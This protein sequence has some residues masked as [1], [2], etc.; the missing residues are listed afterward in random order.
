MKSN[1]L[2]LLV[3]VFL[4]ACAAPIFLSSAESYDPSEDYP[5]AAP[6]DPAKLQKLYEKWEARYIKNG[7]DANLVL[8]LKWSKGLSDEFTKAAGYTKV[9]LIEGKIFVE[10]V[11]LPKE[12]EWDF[13]L[14]DDKPGEGRS[15]M[16]EKTDVMRRVGTL[17]RQGKN[18]SLEANLGPEAFGDFEPDLFIVTQAGKDPT[19]SRIL[20]GYMNLY[21]SLYRSAQKGQFGVL[22]GM[23][24][25]PLPSEKKLSVW[26]RIVN[27]ISPT[28]SAQFSEGPVIQPIENIIAQ[29]KLLFTRETFA[30]NGRTC[31]S[32]HPIANNFTIDPPFIAT[33]P[34]SDPLFVAETNPA[35]AQLEKPLLMRQVG[36]ILENVDGLQNPTV[37]FVMRSVPHTLALPT[38][39]DPDPA[40]HGT[41]TNATGWSGD[42]A[43]NGEQFLLGGN[44]PPHT[45]TGDLFD[46]AIGAVRQHFTKTLNRIPSGGGV[47]GDFR[48]PTFSELAAMEAFQLSLGRQ[49]D[50]IL[51][52]SFNSPLVQ[53]GQ[54]G[55]MQVFGSGTRSCHRCH[56][57][58]GATFNN[59]LDPNDPAN[60]K[61]RNFDTSVEDQP[62]Q[63][64]RL[65]DPTIPIDG[66]FGS[67]PGTQAT[68]FGNQTFNATPVIEA[69]DTGPFFHT[70][71]V[72][73]IEAAVQFYEF[74]FPADFNP[75]NGFTPAM[76][77]AIAAFL[78]A[79]NADE[80]IRS[81]F[82]YA[83]RAKLQF[84]FKPAFELLTFAIADTQ[85]GI[86]VLNG[87][88]LH[89]DA[90]AL[91]DDAV[92][93]LIEAQAQSTQS[94]RN[95]KID[96]ALLKMAQ[97]K[98]I[99]VN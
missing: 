49:D 25:R 38:S 10:A 15:I 70:N 99:I 3:L 60:G 76:S 53:A 97:A 69:A 77:Q 12:R 35:L 92:D 79:I 28:A 66:G 8:P 56:F 93:L 58:A 85:D 18:A 54:A 63:P 96:A 36:L 22:E 78:R 82:E 89:P 23:E 34:P 37:K 27:A 83:E 50:P 21:L 45:T 39:L 40:Q 13:W 73:T 7:G 61:N 86:Q 16:P 42:G 59:I 48:V 14:I 75:A 72:S 11:G 80:N 47:N 88:S 29:G 62:L 67:T 84:S 1:I 19:E 32:C 43:P 2:K 17:K 31:A 20:I 30:G 5:T 33:L 64:G 94:A 57:N 44:P 74:A 26:D 9:N 95:A 52:L 4:M 24:P 91:L 51:P 55:F 46:F 81:A 68:G 6:G 41:F 71:G 65:L 90:A 98:A 87:A